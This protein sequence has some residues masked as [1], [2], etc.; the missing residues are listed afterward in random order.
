MSGTSYTTSDVLG[1]SGA[2][3]EWVDAK[4]KTYQVSLLT[5]EKQ[6]AYERWLE[7]EAVK[8]VKNVRDLLDQDEYNSALDRCLGEISS[9]K[10]IFGGDV[11]QESLGTF[12]GMVAM[13]AILFGISNEEALELTKENKDLPKIIENV[14]T[15][16]FPVQEGNETESKTE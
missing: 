11:A 4:G 6:S 14:I 3:I 15:R 16:S 12:R 5:L 13:I 8:S 1:S 2:K 10:Y 9:G 7:R